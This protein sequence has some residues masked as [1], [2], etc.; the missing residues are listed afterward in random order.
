MERVPEIW[1][2]DARQGCMQRFVRPVGIVTALG[3]QDVPA[4]L[5]Q[6]EAARAKGL[7]TA[8]Y[9][10]YEL[11][12]ALE[13][14][15]HSLL[16]PQRAL[17]LLW[18]GLFEA[19]ETVAPD[20]FAARICG[21]A[22]AGPLKHEWDEYAYAKRF[23][24]VHDYIGAGDIYQAN[25]SFRSQFAF[26]GD[27]RALYWNLRARSGAA[28][29]A[30]IDDGTRQILSL[31]PELFFDLSCDGAL[32]AKP[33]K[34]TAARGADSAADA[35][36]RQALRGSEKDRAENL[37]IVDLL[38]ND[39]GRIAALG[40]VRVEDLFAVETFPTLHQM[41]S[42]V[43]AQLLPR[44][45]IAEI[46]RALFPCGSITGTPKIRAMEVIRELEQSPR[47]VYCGAV[48]HFA[49]NGSARFNVAIRTLTLAN[50]RG[51][52]GIG[53]AIVQDSIAPS[54]Y[55][56][57][58]LKARYYELGRKTIE[59]I[60]TL[61][62]DPAAGF[63]R[64]GLHLARM[65]ASAAALGVPFD[66][67]AAKAV[68]NS[69]VNTGVARVRLTLNEE[70]IFAAAAALLPATPK[71]WTYAISQLS[72]QS[73][74]A[75]LRHKTAWREVYESEQ[76][77]LATH[78]SCDEA[79][80]VNERGELT[81][82]SR[83]NIFLR[84]GGELLTPPLAS[85]ILG[86]CLRRELIESG[87]CREAVLMPDDLACAEDIYLGNSLRGLIRAVPAS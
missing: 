79:I 48:G 82:G 21:R 15:L 45:G 36:A 18:F 34:G 41:V 59:L 3:P 54:E 66:E 20:A 14:R 51:E 80:F 38:R 13:S 77:R 50:G 55:A 42:T 43:K 72:M 19:C 56:E 76:A 85:G 28:H 78:T 6:L 1:L 64:V 5:A 58:V 9:F 67:S 81:E 16:P 40:S 7:H 87:K 47:G 71:T 46:V 32:T 26:V 12:Y 63:V 11:G 53:G 29:C 57:C 33:M 69:V 68:L 83:T 75:L 4:A 65:C 24:R 22:Y 37:M 74:D 17:P 25:L 10:A 31:S 35:M 60:E 27:P 49:P 86:G 39:L 62:F 70:G 84:I 8:G 44:A 73:G 52:L 2:D 30:Y 61:R 23:A